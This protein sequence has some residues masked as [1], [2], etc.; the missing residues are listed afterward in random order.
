MVSK[1]AELCPCRH[2]SIGVYPSTPNSKQELQDVIQSHILFPEVRYAD[3]HEHSLSYC[4][5]GYSL[6][7]KP[8]RDLLIPTDIV[9]RYK[10]HLLHQNQPSSDPP[11]TKDIHDVHCQ[12][13][14][15]KCLNLV[16]YQFLQFLD[17]AILSLQ[18]S[19]IV[20]VALARR[21]APAE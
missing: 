10:G 11:T 2:V 5:C 6:R 4:R 8:G 7:C 12:F 14:F 9:G 17:S 16:L 20:A 15:C 13:I 19:L 1:P 21:H 18:K 3:C